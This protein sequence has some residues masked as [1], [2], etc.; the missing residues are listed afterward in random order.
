MH[1]HSTYSDGVDSI[2]ANIEQATKIG[3]ERLCCVDHVR[4]DTDWLPEFAAHIER[5]RNTSKIA[6]YSGIET[7]LLNEAGDLDMPED[8]SGIDYTYVADHQFPLGD[9]CYHPKE[10]REM[11]RD[12]KLDS[13]DAIGA[14]CRATINAVKR[15]PNVVLAHLFSVLP[16]AGL[17]EEMV[18]EDLICEIADAAKRFGAKI[19][20][21]ERWKCPS[22]RTISY[23]NERQVPVW[24][25]SDS[26][27]KETI[28]VY[29]YNAGINR[30]MLCA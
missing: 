8:I 26:H 5:L 15:N 18:P 23:F 4:R 1:V 27:R 12:G 20:I 21:D 28:G 16:K 13:A 17:S 11:I 30:E 25:S 7:K 9:K 29:D 10:I 24:F 22:L 14:L 19:E 2:E 6:L 3:L